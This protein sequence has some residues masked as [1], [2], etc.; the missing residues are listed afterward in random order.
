MFNVN[1]PI[2]QQ[3]AGPSAAQA[4]P[5]VA[6]AGQKLAQAQSMLNALLDRVSKETADTLEL[7]DQ[8]LQ[9]HMQ[10]WTADISATIRDA[11]SSLG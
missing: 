9:Q 11:Q 6:A 4:Q 10:Q 5:D 7:S 2:S 1:H 3:C 8:T